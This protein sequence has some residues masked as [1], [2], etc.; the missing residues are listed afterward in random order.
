MIIKSPTIEN[1]NGMKDFNFRTNQLKF[2]DAVLYGDHNYT[3]SYAPRQNG[4]TSILKYCADILQNKGHNVLIILRQHDQKRYL[5]TINYYDGTIPD[6]FHISTLNQICKTPCRYD[7]VLWDEFDF[8]FR[9]TNGS[10]YLITEVITTL[11][12]GNPNVRI[13]GMTTPNM[14]HSIDI[15]YMLKSIIDFKIIE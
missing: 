13:H 2:F 7:Y 12:A 3:L 6:K 10:D 8:S 4:S 14:T 5:P 9:N 15:Q 11:L 1:Y